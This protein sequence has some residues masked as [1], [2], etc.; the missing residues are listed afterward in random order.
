LTVS[1]GNSIPGRIVST[2]TETGALLGNCVFFMPLRPDPI[3][4]E[5]VRRF[6][7][8]LEGVIETPHF[9][10]A[11]WRVGGRIFATAPPTSTHI[12]AFVD[13]A[14]REQALALHPGF[15][16]KLLWGGKVVGV[17][18]ELARATAEA[19][20]ALVRA[21]WTHRRQRPVRARAARAGG[22]RG[23]TPRLRPKL[24]LPST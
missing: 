5:G 19:T 23:G 10:F 12:H 6:A 14:T 3:D 2:N 1:S 4:L 15:V 13:E 11:S 17:R 9:D 8:G 21:A 16:E 24:D 20:L 18:V 7:L 22:P